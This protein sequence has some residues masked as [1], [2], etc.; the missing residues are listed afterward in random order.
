MKEKINTKYCC[1][2]GLCNNI[3]GGYINEKGFFR[4][5]KELKEYEFDANICYYNY[6]NRMKISKFWG[7]IEGIYYGYSQNN[8]TRK[9]ASSGGML[10]EIAQFLLKEN[11]VDCIIQIRA[12]K[13][14]ELETEVIW[15]TEV[16]EILKCS[17]SRYT[18]SASL[19]NILKELDF[20]KKYAVIGKPCDIRVLREYL[21][22]HKEYNEVIVYLL[23]FFCAGTPSINANINLIKQMNISKEKLKKFTYRGNGWP[24]KTT[25][26]TND[27]KEVSLPYETSGGKY[28]GRDLQNICRFCWEGVGEAA[29]ISCGDG[30]YV[31]EGKPD[32]S[33]KNGRNIILARSLKGKHLL[34]EMQDK[35]MIVINEIENN[36]IL[37]VMQPNH[38]MRKSSMFAS[39]LAM[40]IMFRQAPSY[41]LRELVRY[42]RNISI[43]DNIKIF[44]GTLKRIVKRK[45]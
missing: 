39:I 13:D 37:D 41:K 1:G 30:W 35:G 34:K 5:N 10:T 2:C 16:E 21:K 15:N 32:F 31:K 29:D 12:K 20:S 17:G 43:K 23:S 22:T 18:A 40:K 4:P 19:I 42:S 24:G 8:T 28:L 27:N 25:A 36:S 45:I 44:F 33:E 7:E 6:L 38:F 26:I 11:L 9:L 14:N 3:K